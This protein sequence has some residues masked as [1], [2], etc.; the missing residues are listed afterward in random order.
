MT[1]GE[2]EAQLIEEVTRLAEEVIEL[3]AKIEKLEEK[4][5]CW[6]DNW[7]DSENER[8]HAAEAVESAQEAF[9]D[10][11]G[12]TLLSFVGIYLELRQIRLRLGHVGLE[13]PDDR[14]RDS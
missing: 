4:N 13:L 9:A 12:L 14:K 1:P 3:K 7:I 6:E 2:Q 5:E 11:I 10:A 8:I